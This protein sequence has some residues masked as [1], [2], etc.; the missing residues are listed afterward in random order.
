MMSEKVKGF[1]GGTFVATGTWMIVVNFREFL[2]E[3]SPITNQ[4]VI[5]MLLIFIGGWITANDIKKTIRRLIK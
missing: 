2:L 5:G 3:V 1:I 4:Y